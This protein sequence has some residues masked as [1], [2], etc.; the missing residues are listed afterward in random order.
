MWEI[1][2]TSSLGADEGLRPLR[3]VTGRADGELRRRLVWMAAIRIVVVTLVLAGGSYF[4]LLGGSPDGERA[5]VTLTALVLGLNGL[6]I[7]IALLLRAG[8]QLRQLAMLQVGG[9]L[10]FALALLYLTGVDDSLFSFILPLVAVSGGALLGDRGAWCSA[11][12]AFLGY[13]VVLFLAQQG[14]LQPTAFTGPIQARHAWQALFAHGSAI[15]LTAGLMAY[16]LSQARSAG[17]RAEA[18]ESVLVRLHVLHDSIVRSIGS[19]ILTT[20][21]SGRI[22]FVNRAGEKILEQKLASLQGQPLEAI[23]PTVREGVAKQQAFRQEA[24]WRT[25]SGRERLLGFALTPLRDPAG[26]ILGTTAVFQD[27]TELR[28]LEE[29]AA[30][31]ERL[32]VVGELAA[33]LA[34]ELRNPLASIFG[35]IEMLA[36]EERA[37]NQRLFGIVLRETQRLNRLVSEFLA[38]ASPAAPTLQP[39][40]LPELVGSTLD[41]F[42]L[43]PAAKGLRIERRVE[44]AWVLADEDQLRQVLWNLLLNAAQASESGACISV[45][46]RVEGEDRVLLFVED[47]GCGIPPHLKD[48]IFDPFFTT[49]ESGSGLGLPVIH[50]VVESFGGTLT[51]RSEVGVGTRFSIA[52]PRADGAEA[53]GA[54]GRV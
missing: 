23:F 8:H 13:A 54:L 30:R 21:R 42:A 12:A 29:R 2:N 52:L 15:F 48:K 17:E 36:Q 51:V 31:S 41:V 20:D 49:K 45:E 16:V 3:Y 46:C 25:P 33:G 7:V 22:T 28:E 43:D 53:R 24:A 10:V 39:V 35:A 1:G 5:V 47:E 26:K 34:H 9:D 11:L 4:L 37:E 40:D 19:G 18:A 27:L 38:F 32:A 50:R 44:P 14:I 6:Q